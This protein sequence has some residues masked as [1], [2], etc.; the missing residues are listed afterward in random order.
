MADNNLLEELKSIKDI[1][2]DS[3]ISELLGRLEGSG[4][5]AEEIAGYR[6]SLIKRRG[7]LK[8][9][10]QKESGGFETVSD[11]TKLTE[12]QAAEKSKF[13]EEN[14]T[15]EDIAKTE[16]MKEIREFL[17]EEYAEE[18]DMLEDYLVLDATVDAFAAPGPICTK[19]AIDK[20]CRNK[21]QL[22]SAELA[23]AVWQYHCD[24]K[25][26]D[27]NAQ[28][29]AA[30]EK[31]D[32]AEIERIQ[33]EI[34]ATEKDMLTTVS[35]LKDPRLKGIKCDNPELIYGYLG[36]KQSKLEEK[37]APIE[38]A[39]GKVFSA[40]D[41]FRA[42]EER[43]D[44]KRKL[45]DLENQLEEAKKK[46]DLEKYNKLQ[47]EIKKT[48][49]KATAY[50]LG[51]GALKAVSNYGGLML[52]SFCFPIAGPA[53]WAG[54]KGIYQVMEMQHEYKK[55]QKA[56]FDKFQKLSVAYKEAQT[57]EEKKKILADMGAQKDIYTKDFKSYIKANPEKAVGAAISCATSGLLFSAVVIPGFETTTARV[58]SALGGGVAM[59]SVEVQKA[60]E[61][62]KAAKAAGNEE[63]AKKMRKE[64]WKHVGRSALKVG[65]GTLSAGFAM[66]AG[67]IRS[68]GFENT[69]Q[70]F[71]LGGAYAKAIAWMDEH[72]FG[73]GNTND[74]ELNAELESATVDN[75]AKMNQNYS[76]LNN[77][78][79]G[80]D[81]MDAKH[82][83]GS[84]GAGVDD[85][86]T[87]P[88]RQDM[89][90]Y[91]TDTKTHNL[92]D[93]FARKD[94][95]DFSAYL[96]KNGLLSPENEAYYKAHG[97]LPESRIDAMIA[98]GEIPQEHVDGLKQV[99][100]EKKPDIDKFYEDKLRALREQKSQ[101]DNVDGGGKS[102]IPG[103]G[104][105]SLDD[106]SHDDGTPDDTTHDE[107]GEE[108][109][110]KKSKFS[111]S[112]FDNYD[113]SVDSNASVMKRALAGKPINFDGEA[114]DYEGK[115]LNERLNILAK[116]NN[117]PFGQR[118]AFVETAL[119]AKEHG[120]QMSVGV[121]ENGKPQ[122]YVFD[123][124]HTSA[125]CM[126]GVRAGKVDDFIK[127][128]AEHGNGNNSEY[129]D[130]L[131]ERFCE[132]AHEVTDLQDDDI[133]NHKDG[134]LL[135]DNLKLVAE[136]NQIPAGQ[137]DMFV[138]A[139]IVAKDN[140]LKVS[141]IRDGE[142]GCEFFIS[143]KDGN[144]I[145][146]LNDENVSGLDK[147]VQRL[148][149]IS[150]KADLKNLSNNLASEGRSAA[151]AGSSPAPT[152]PTPTD[153]TTLE[154]SES[155]DLTDTGTHGVDLAANEMSKAEFGGTQH[156]FSDGSAYK[157]GEDGTYHIIGKGSVSVEDKAAM[158][159]LYLQDGKQL[160]STNVMEAEVTKERVYRDLLNR[161]NA[162][163]TLSDGEK[164]FMEDRDYELNSKNIIRNED[165]TLRKMTQ[166]EIAD[167]RKTH[168]GSIFDSPV[169]KRAQSKLHD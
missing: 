57:E 169:F 66:F 116:D 65:T 27:L 154:G 71:G 141:L 26:V 144:L 61:A 17:G 39:F 109:G 47:E 35:S 85:N 149:G 11:W 12:E 120:L 112:Q 33:A 166:T 119:A 75:A 162:H 64:A 76:I 18:A 104:E 167:W 24:S 101:L 62:F 68:S 6:K 92:F 151:A 134:K 55:A 127:D 93:E 124:N 42:W 4:L 99:W 25:L 114:F 128:F 86:V 9:G 147:E 152:D 129:I 83:Q 107:L 48:K 163:E 97:V 102:E 117:I 69:M 38:K 111:E 88:F 45:I 133:W 49:K 30:E 103:E 148:A 110:G 94:P 84:V 98:K 50:N 158:S 36:M 139:A 23:N 54:A 145:T 165:G 105:D 80:K 140:D 31:K 143:D 59:A 138:A 125:A 22:A 168:T 130:K 52:S 19:A 132:R 8:N 41:R 32:A 44:P 81:F 122:F 155:A 58:A 160:M 29:K 46:N 28:L 159:S 51:K 20:A 82:F 43:I 153:P 7:E 40:V 108:K 118:R 16:G 123:E 1:T 113:N 136:K 37:M 70:K 142:G 78:Q 106:A 13:L 10:G 74:A 126:S 135:R 67:E 115:Q 90:S 60:V 53:V 164:L 15:K 121:G 56:A 73:K 89:P 150:G 156:R 87:V 5:S 161:Q 3:K 77:M 137:R 91:I 63:E 21:T 96:H 14:L 2:D 157:I 95:R 72:N 100:A 34:K 146:S 79:Q 131:Q